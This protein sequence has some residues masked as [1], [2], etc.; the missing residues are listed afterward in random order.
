MELGAAV[1]CVVWEV[2]EF[3]AG[4][5][6]TTPPRLVE[7]ANP[8]PVRHRIRKRTAFIGKTLD[9]ESVPLFHNLIRCCCGLP[10]HSAERLGLSRYGPYLGGYASELRRSLRNEV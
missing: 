8:T 7:Q 4:G 9:A 10:P 3:L 5:V 1:A 6:E 2:L